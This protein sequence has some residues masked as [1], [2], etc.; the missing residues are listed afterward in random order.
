MNNGIS[1]YPGLDNTLEEN[2]NLI[3]TASKRGL[4]R[5]FTSL[6]IPET[7][8][9]KL[10]QELSIILS[11][12]KDNDMEIIS[13]ISPKTTEILGIDGRDLRAFKKLGITALRLDYGYNAETIAKFSR[14]DEGIKIVLNASAINAEILSDLEK[15]N[16]DFSGIE[17]LHNFYPR[18]NTG[19]AEEFF[20]A[21]TK[22]LQAYGIK[23][24]AFV[25]SEGKKRGPMFEGIPTLE[26]HRD[27]DTSLAARH[28]TALGTDFIV[29]SES[30]P[31]QSE[32]ES[33]A[34][35]KS[36]EVVLK[37]KLFTKDKAQIELLSNT[38]TAREDEA[39]DVIRA[40]EGRALLKG[41]IEP[42]NNIPRKI[43]AI[44]V[45]NKNYQRYMGELQIIKTPLPCD[46]RVNVVGQVEDSELFMMKYILP[47][48]KFSFEV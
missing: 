17:A 28:L 10:K 23:V 7:D 41:T 3:E 5:I 31:L 24:G 36:N 39:R 16:A 9:A 21:K 22:L 46:E 18:K 38:F 1:L 40:A 27:T 43:G 15:H 34:K 30:L 32:M 20:T 11:G 45:D 13:D 37:A 19:L 6:H 26:A 35:L 14:N 25:S 4:K 8:K 33:L 44:T 29:I 42:E 48:V 2:L 12:A 47:G